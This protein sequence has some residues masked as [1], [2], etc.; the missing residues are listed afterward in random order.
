MPK[1]RLV[2]IL[3]IT[4]VLLFSYAFTHYAYSA[5]STQGDLDKINNE[6]SAITEEL[7]KSLA[8]TKPLES[9]LQNIQ[10]QIVS[11][12]NQV[13][14]VERDMVV[15]KKE[16][17]NGYA[18]LAKKEKILSHTIRDFYVD[19]YYDSPLLIFF[20]HGTM[21]DV[22][23]TLAY[24]R[25]RTEQ[26]RTVMTNIALS[27]TDLEKKKVELEQQQKWLVTTKASLDQQSA[28]LDETVKNAKDYQ[29]KLS[30]QIAE[31]TA[32]Q[33]QLI[34]Q[35]QSSLNLPKTAYN[36]SRGCSSDLT[37]GKSPGFSPAIGFFTFGVPN[38]VGMNQYAAKARAEAGQNAE[39]I[40]KAYF[41]ADLT[42]NYQ[43]DVTIHVTG[44][45]EFGQSFDDS[46][47][48]EDYVKHVYEM[49]TSWPTEALKAQAIAARSIALARTNNGANPICPSQSCQVVKKELNDSTWQAVVDATRGMVL[50]NGGQPISAWF[51]ITHGG[52]VYNSGDI[53]WNATSFTKNALDA[54]GPVNSFA[55]LKANAYDKDSPWFYCDWGSRGDYGGTAWLKPSEV[56][57]IANVILLA[58]YSD[59]DKEHLYQPDKSNPSGKETWNADKIKAELKSR[60]G[61]P[62]DSVSD[63]SVSVDFG[64][65]RT[66]SVNIGGTS[67]GASEFKDWFNLRAPANI[68]IVGPLFNIEKQ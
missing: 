8:A 18:E 26:E 55:D 29:S 67:F 48:I 7:K 66:T 51:S 50:T 17:D 59:V 49:Y 65:G 39:T 34:A 25:A 57:D 43:T 53:G 10:Q 9:Q 56:A 46:W 33:K 63:A 38:R 36:T 54:S 41:N 12:K 3:C 6:L 62:L 22:T 40:L 11:I 21:S 16:I 31:L 60:G 64:S 44:S 2:S 4:A 47:N 37:N 20:S 15:K 23:Q 5:P 52:Y 27:V 14:A 13:A 19:S 28:K 24:Q 42:S 35:K 1:K 45:N 68:Q 61:S 32:Q 58:R 30:K